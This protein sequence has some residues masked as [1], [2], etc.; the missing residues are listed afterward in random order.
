MKRITCSLC[1]GTGVSYEIQDPVEP[2]TKKQVPAIE[3]QFQLDLPPTPEE[4]EAWRELERKH[5]RLNG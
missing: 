4:E 5:P 2:S 1:G 3:K